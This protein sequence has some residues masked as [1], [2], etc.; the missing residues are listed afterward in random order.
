M[1]TK[2]VSDRLVLQVSLHELGPVL[3]SVRLLESR[4]KWGRGT[5]YVLNELTSFIALH[6]RPWCVGLVSKKD[7]FLADGID[8]MERD[9]SGDEQIDSLKD[10]RTQFPIQEVPVVS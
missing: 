3:S 5:G 2:V 9:L 4:R 10:Q 8:V 6:P 1:G 7:H